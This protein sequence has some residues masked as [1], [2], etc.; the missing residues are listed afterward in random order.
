[1]GADINAKDSEERIALHIAVAHNY[2]EVVELLLSKG[3]AVDALNKKKESAILSEIRRLCN[4]LVVKHVL[5]EQG[6]NL[7]IW[8]KEG[9][10]YAC[11]NASYDVF[12][13]FI[14]AGLKLDK[15]CLEN[16]VSKGNIVLL[17]RAIRLG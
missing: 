9:L 10:I 3:A 7:N 1:M 8:G 4:Y 14:Q 16:I 17:D 6:L 15:A 11:S 12:E 5:L 13:R 2:N